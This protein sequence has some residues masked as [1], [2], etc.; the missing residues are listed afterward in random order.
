MFGLVLYFF[1]KR[2]RDA[3]VVQ[4]DCKVIKL[5]G[6]VLSCNR[7][8]SSHKIL[9]G[10]LPSVGQRCGPAAESTEEMRKFHLKPKGN[11]RTLGR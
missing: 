7:N 6:G 4:E 10:C 9:N 1:Y 5:F 8:V 11:A 2:G 3:D